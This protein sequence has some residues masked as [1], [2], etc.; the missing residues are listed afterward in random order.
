MTPD[1][2]VMRPEKKHHQAMEGPQDHEGEGMVPDSTKGG[3]N[4]KN[5]IKLSA[6][7]CGAECKCSQS[8]DGSEPTAPHANKI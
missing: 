8:A 5:S 2:A 7:P 6:E 3:H 1:D 4:C